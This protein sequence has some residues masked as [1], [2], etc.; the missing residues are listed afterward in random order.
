MSSLSFWRLLGEPSASAVVVSTDEEGPVKCDH[1][2]SR[3]GC[4]ADSGGPEV[5]VDALLQ[6]VKLKAW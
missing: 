2:L 1:G 4:S 5:L 3:A 6:P